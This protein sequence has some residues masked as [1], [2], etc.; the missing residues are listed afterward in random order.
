MSL[1]GERLDKDILIGFDLVGGLAG[2]AEFDCLFDF[3]VDARK[4]CFLLNQLFGFN[5]AL[6]QLISDVNNP[7]V[8]PYWD[9]KLEVMQ[10]DIMSDNQL[11]LEIGELG[12]VSFMPSACLVCRHNLLQLRALLCC[13]M[14]F[15]KRHCFKHSIF[16]DVVYVD[17]CSVFS[18]GLSEKMTTHVVGRVE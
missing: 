18:S 16:G 14:N 3:L 11:F 17:F 2:N 4:P 8:K 7:L 1:Q 9:D 13:F 10:N 12:Q 6:M 5:R 15:I